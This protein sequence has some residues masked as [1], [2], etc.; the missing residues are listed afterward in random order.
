MYVGLFVKYL[1]FQAGRS[2]S[3][4]VHS[5]P[6]VDACSTTRVFGVGMVRD[7]KEREKYVGNR[8]MLFFGTDFKFGLMPFDSLPGPL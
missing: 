8:R 6:D 5:S 2:L 3:R 4:A 1:N 7:K